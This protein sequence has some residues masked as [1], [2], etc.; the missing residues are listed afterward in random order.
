VAESRKSDHSDLEASFLSLHGEQCHLDRLVPV[1]VKSVTEIILAF[2]AKSCGLD[3]LP[4]PLLKKF[5]SVLAVPITRI[6][7]ASLAS[8]LVTDSLKHTVITPLIKKSSL[9]PQD[10]SNYRP[11]SRLPFLS[12]LIER[13]VLRQLTSHIE[14]FQLLPP[15]LSAYRVN[16][17]TE[18]SLLAIQND[19]L[20]AAD[21]GMGSALLILDLS[22]AFDT[23]DNQRLLK[24]LP[25]T[26]GVT[27]SSL[28]WCQSY[29]SG[30]TQS[31]KALGDTSPPTPL[32]FGVPQGSVL[33][34]TLFSIYTSP[35][36]AIASRH[37]VRLSSFL[38]IPMSTFISTWIPT[39]SLWLLAH[40][41]TLL[42]TPR[43]GLTTTA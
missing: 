17:S 25:S 14:D 37:G 42:L 27:G 1:S 24:R 10:F 23:V 20:S 4:T 18:T 16:Y 12:K 22:A 29:L 21:A 33:G 5:L 2:P 26:F 3:P 40:L 43:I 41:V 7:N 13:V 6:V 8:G 28:G 32:S 30:P 19:L 9:D 11:V 31:V 39:V 35:L 15:S 34:P 38:T 36:S